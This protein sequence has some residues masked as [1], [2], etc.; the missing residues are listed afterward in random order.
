MSC[1]DILSDV[2]HNFNKIIEILEENNKIN[3]IIENHYSIL[4][5]ICNYADYNN[6]LKI[7]KYN[8]D[9]NILTNCE[10]KYSCLMLSCMN[11]NETKFL[12]IK[13]M[14]EN[15]NVNINYFN[16]ENISCLT[17]LYNNLHNNPN[18]IH[19]INYIL[20]NNFII[21]KNN[22]IDI[23]D[24]NNAELLE[25][26]IKYKIDLD[27][28]D[29][30]GRTLLGRACDKHKKSIIKILLKHNVSLIPKNN[31]KLINIFTEINNKDW[32]FNYNN[33][34]KI[35]AIATSK[36]FD[37][38]LLFHLEDINFIQFEHNKH[39]KVSY[40]N[41]IFD[42]KNL[43]FAPN[44]DSNYTL[45]KTYVIR[46]RNPCGAKYGEIKTIFGEIYLESIER[47]PLELALKSNNIEVFDSL[48][49]QAIIRHKLDSYGKKII[50][51]ELFFFILYLLSVIIHSILQ[52]NNNTN[53]IYFNILTIIF[54]I[55]FGIKELKQLFPDDIWH[56]VKNN[57]K[58]NNLNLYYKILFHIFFT[59]ICFIIGIFYHYTN[60]WNWLDTIYIIGSIIA[61][62]YDFNNDISKSRSI[63]SIVSILLWSKLLYY[64]RCFNHT[65]SFI[66]LLLEA[67]KDMLPFLSVLSIIILA[68]THACYIIFQPATFPYLSTSNTYSI[69]EYKNPLKAIITTYRML[70]GDFDY[71]MFKDTEHYIIA[72]ILF[73]GFT[74]IVIIVI[75]NLLISLLGNTFERVQKDYKLWRLYEKA[76]LLS[77]VDKLFNYNLMIDDS[78]QRD[79]KKFPDWLA[80]SVKTTG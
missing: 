9:F 39:I 65:A 2:K 4:H 47:N 67:L 29:N 3:E 79:K 56:K 17:I 11:N 46:L 44:N 27:I 16:S 71:V 63:I 31:I 68:F 15:R 76:G 50:Y 40:T 54:S 33:I 80:I 73:I 36:W 19:I 22:I 8:P 30:N 24:S 58:Y 49:I 25:I 70:F 12:I 13:D 42:E 6:Y 1:L 51:T 41:D 37:N 61:M 74:L 21:S 20:S 32:S 48:A 78:N 72:N 66:T 35:P 59:P 43:Y 55:L 23:I 52:A 45:V 5:Y 64:L 57:N 62:H 60:I 18:N 77:D 38:N 69:D 10:N 75:L 34:I 26:F 14:I 53:K 28:I 7:I